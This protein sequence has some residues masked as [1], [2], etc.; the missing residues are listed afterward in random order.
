M[1]IDEAQV[2]ADNMTYEEAIMN[3]FQSKGIKYRKATHIKL[4][5][6]LEELKWYCSQDL[7]QKID[8]KGKVAMFY[9]EFFSAYPN[10]IPFEEAIEIFIDI[11]DYT[12][13]AEPPKERNGDCETCKN[14][15]LKVEDV[16]IECLNGANHYEPC[17]PKE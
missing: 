15:T 13:K 14:I 17:I 4:N 2:F 9:Q 16:C 3:T 10:G 5:K 1:K 12:P 7:I 8:A 11:I 6:M